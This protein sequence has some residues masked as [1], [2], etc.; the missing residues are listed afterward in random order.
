MTQ[1]LQRSRCSAQIPLA[2]TPVPSGDS[3]FYA[4]QMGSLKSTNKLN[5]FLLSLTISSVQ[6]NGPSLAQSHTTKHSFSFQRI[7]LAIKTVNGDVQCSLREV[8]VPERFLKQASTTLDH[9]KQVTCWPW[10]S[11]VP[12]LPP[13]S[14]HF[15]SNLDGVFYCKDDT[16]H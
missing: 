16:I 10:Q 5:N 1:S 7:K 3:L 4:V 12:L 8:C 11:W 14:K 13:S 2:A 15:L 6:Q 9:L